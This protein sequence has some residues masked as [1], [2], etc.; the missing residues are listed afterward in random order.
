MSAA[1]KEQTAESF[2]EWRK[3]VKDHWYHVRLL[4]SAWTDL[5][6]AREGSL[7]NLETWLGD[8]HNLV[9]LCAKLNESP[10]SFGE[11]AD[12]Q[13]FLALST[14]YQKELRE[15]ALSLGERLYE[16]KPGQFTQ[17]HVEAVGCMASA[18]QRAERDGRSAKQRRSEAAGQVRSG[19]AQEI[20]GCVA[21]DTDL[22]RPILPLPRKFFNVP[23]TQPFVLLRL[24][25][26]QILDISGFGGCRAIFDRQLIPGR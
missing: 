26:S 3:R 2:H 14:Q 20:G 16:E 9:V 23:E 21:F 8:D 17:K 10:D 5:L 19:Q 18:T 15:N 12:I 1:R 25:I 13:L 22:I 6:R 11:A 24:A 4:E 7:K